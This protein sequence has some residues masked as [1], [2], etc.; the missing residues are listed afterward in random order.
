MDL[1]GINI[2]YQYLV[3]YLLIIKF[4]LLIFSM[5]DMEYIATLDNV[6]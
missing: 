3:D 5:E 1:L 2:F 4:Q 6:D